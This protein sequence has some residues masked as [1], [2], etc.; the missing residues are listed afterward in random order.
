[1]E[2]ENPWSKAQK[3]KESVRVRGKARSMCVSVYCSI[4]SLHCTALSLLTSSLRFR[5]LLVK[6]FE[7][8]F[9][10]LP[11]FYFKF[12]PNFLH[13]NTTN[14]EDSMQIIIE[15]MITFLSVVK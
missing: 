15:T 6:T 11:F 12:V 14:Y 1:M 5:L 4:S 7:N 13:Y 10:I 3:E 9:F 8:H 2:I